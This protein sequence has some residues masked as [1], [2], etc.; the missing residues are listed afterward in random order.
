[1]SK[2]MRK[3]TVMIKKEDYTAGA[4]LET[5]ICRNPDNAPDAWN[6]RRLASRQARRLRAGVR[7]GHDKALAIN[8][9]NKGGVRMAKRRTCSSTCTLSGAEQM[10]Q[11]G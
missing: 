4:L 2:E 3:A 7:G 9:D 1:M 6:F 5:E 10:P 11:Y 8:L